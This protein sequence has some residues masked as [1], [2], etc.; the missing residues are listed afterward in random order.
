[1]KADEE[2]DIL[3]NWKIRK[4]VLP[5]MYLRILSHSPLSVQDGKVDDLI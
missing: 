1:M 3:G 2:D 5:P 4:H